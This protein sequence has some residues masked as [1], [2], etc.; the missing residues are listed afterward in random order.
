[1]LRGA[2]TYDEEHGERCR[3]TVTLATGIPEDVVRAANL[4]YL[5]PAEVDAEAYAADPGTLVVPE[6]GEVLY[7][8]R[9]P[10]GAGRRPGPAGG[11]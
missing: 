8:L 2:G 7:R 6:A 4:N 9:P 3:V 10:S 5:D 1:H 11:R